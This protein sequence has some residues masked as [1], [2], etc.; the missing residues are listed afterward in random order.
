[1]VVRYDST[2]SE[3]WFD[4]GETLLEYG[5]LKESLKAFNRCVDLQPKWSDPYYSRA[6]VL[7]MMHKTFDAIESLK[8]S[9]ELDPEKKK[10]FESEFPGVRS[11]KEIVNLLGR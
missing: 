1:M 9:F 8:Y 2:N 4:L 7:F 11:I 3:A 5:Y 10:Y 6:K